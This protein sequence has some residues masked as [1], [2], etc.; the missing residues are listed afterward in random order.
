[1]HTKPALHG[2]EGPH[3]RSSTVDKQPLT[4]KRRREVTTGFMGT[5]GSPLPGLIS[6]GSRE[7]SL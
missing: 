5:P 6:S 2:R 4:V 1:V 3:Q 7:A